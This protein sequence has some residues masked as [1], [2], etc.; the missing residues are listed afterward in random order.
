M[1]LMDL[2]ERF[3]IIFSYKF[4]DFVLFLLWNL[5]VPQS[6]L[7]M[8]NDKSEAYTDTFTCRFLKQLFYESVD[9]S[10][11]LGS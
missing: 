7:C 10:E 6:C 2:C 9:P 11:F 5:P 3:I 1:T 8:L 4:D